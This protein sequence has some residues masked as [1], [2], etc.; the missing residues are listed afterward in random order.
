MTKVE[1][2]TIN[3]KA[4]SIRVRNNRLEATVSQL[5]GPRLPG[6]SVLITDIPPEQHRAMWDEAMEMLAAQFHEIQELLGMTR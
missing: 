4:H 5:H 2:E 6:D 3:R 1:L